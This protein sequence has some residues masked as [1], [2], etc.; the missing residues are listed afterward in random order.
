MKV[1]IIA[2]SSIVFG[3]ELKENL[4]LFGYEIYLLDFESL[5]LINP[6]NTQNKNYAIQ[7]LKYK[8]IPKLSMLFR[9]MYIKTIL[10]EDNFELVN[11]HYSRWVYLLILGRLKKIKFIITFYGSDFYRVSNQIKKMQIYIYKTASAISFTNPLTKQSFLEYYNDYSVKSFVCRFGLETL[12]F[13]DKNRD[14]NKIEIKKVLGYNEEKIIVTC[15]YNST[16]SQQHEKII[17]AIEK[18]D[19]KCKFRCQFIFPLTYGDTIQKELLKKTLLSANFDYLI[20][21]NFLYEDENAFIKLGSD[22]M[23]NILET[24]SFSG[25]MQE[26]L[27][28]KNIVITGS[29]LPYEVFDKAGIIYEKINYPSELTN[30]LTYVINNLQKLKENLDKNKMIIYELSSWKNCIGMW[31]KMYHKVLYG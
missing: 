17:E 3:K 30:K 24:D 23:I 27:Y 6:D 18:L 13:I 2:N 12:D 10:K 21:E 26:F 8:R 25:T 29:W 9:M 22:V 1:L 28:A 15:G 4:N 7:F 14:K 16:K 5:V 31:N 19:S 20:L 11:I